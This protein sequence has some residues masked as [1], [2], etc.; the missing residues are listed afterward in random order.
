MLCEPST[1]EQ[2]SCHYHPQ[3]PRN[4][5]PSLSSVERD[6]AKTLFLVATELAETHSDSQSSIIRHQRISISETFF[7]KC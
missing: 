2:C 6:R 7:K 1:C 4:V 5:H 3:E